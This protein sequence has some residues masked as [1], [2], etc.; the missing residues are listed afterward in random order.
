ME[1][2]IK[3]PFSNQWL[4]NVANDLFSPFIQPAPLVQEDIPMSSQ[5]ELEIILDSHYLSQLPVNI[6]FEY[7]DQQNCLQMAQIEVI[8]DSPIQADSFIKVRSAESAFY[9]E[10][11]QIINVTAITHNLIA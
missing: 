6:L 4:Q 11:N 7:Y 10:L 8:I 2:P 5:K 3:N 9:L 1:L